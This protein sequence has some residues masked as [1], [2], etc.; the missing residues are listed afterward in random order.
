MVALITVRLKLP[1]QPL[2]VAQITVC[3]ESPKY[4][5]VAG[6]PNNRPFVVVQ[7]TVA[8]DCSNN[9]LFVAA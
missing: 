7:I 4:S 1:K 9:R 6:R 2:L 8:T 5:F 3:L